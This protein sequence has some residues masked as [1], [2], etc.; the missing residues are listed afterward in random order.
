MVLQSLVAAVGLGQLRSQAPLELC[1]LLLVPLLVALAYWAW[2]AWAAAAE[3]PP[4]PRTV[5]VSGAASGLG[6]QTCLALAARGDFVVA[7]DLDGAL[8]DALA[9]ELGGPQRCLACVC[10]VASP[11]SCARAAAALGPRHAVVDAVANF[12]GVIR[13]GPLM[14]QDPADLQL[15]L[16]VNVRGTHHVTQAFFPRMIQRAGPEGEGRARGE[17][18]VVVVASELSASWVS[19]GFNAPYSM[20]KFA[21]EAYAV[22]LR[23]EMLMLKQA[24]PSRR[25]VRVVVVN[26]GAMRTPLLAAQMRGG[27][28]AF[29]ERHAARPEGTLWEAPLRKG[30]AV[31]QGY[32][33]RHGGDPQ[34]VADVV[35]RAVHAARPLDRYLVGVSPEMRL[36]KHV[37]QWLLDQ[38]M[39]WLQGST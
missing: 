6:R 7:L 28:N 8:L 18:T 10:D 15:V 14:E 39:L 3:G 16:D 12:A 23:Q 31:A 13:G 37:P 11:D 22:A 4:G 32:M 26:P 34:R 9:T 1:A 25:A 30:A 35:V 2:S 33:E 19:A 24:D 17:G 5:V 36:A 21:L 20:S 27:S 29:F 38:A